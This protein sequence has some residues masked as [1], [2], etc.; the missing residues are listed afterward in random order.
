METRI[1]SSGL[2]LL[3]PLTINRGSHFP[4]MENR[5]TAEITAREILHSTQ[6]LPGGGG[7]GVATDGNKIGVEQYTILPSNDGG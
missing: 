1:F 2:F 6:N 4:L 3:L 7:C 5:W